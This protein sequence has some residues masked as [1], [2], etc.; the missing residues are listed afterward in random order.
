MEVNPK[1]IP[2]LDD[3]DAYEGYIVE[4]LRKASLEPLP[5]KTILS[6]EELKE[7]NRNI[8]VTTLDDAIN[9]AH[10]ASLWPVTCFTACCTFEFIATSMARFDIARFGM[11]VRMDCILR[12]RISF[13]T[14][15]LSRPTTFILGRARALEASIFLTVP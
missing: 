12:A 6:E 14:A 2:S 5:E 7:L 9:W 4:D 11:E 1:L 10:K 8:I 3:A 15:S 13:C